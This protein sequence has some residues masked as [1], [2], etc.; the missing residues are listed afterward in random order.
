[1]ESNESMKEYIV[2]INVICKNP[3]LVSKVSEV[4]ARAGAG[5]TLEGL[6]VCMNMAELEAERIEENP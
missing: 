1:M 2:S 3:H 6:T 5:L 4:F